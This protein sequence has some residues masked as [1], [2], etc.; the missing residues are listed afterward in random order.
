MRRMCVWCVE[1]VKDWLTN[2]DLTVRRCL[3]DLV[4]GPHL[5]EGHSSHDEDD[6]SW[7]RLLGRLALEE[8]HKELTQCW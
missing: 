4:D 7:P 2:D 6:D 8:R 5:R 1:R 3:G